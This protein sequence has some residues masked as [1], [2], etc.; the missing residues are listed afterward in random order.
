MIWFQVSQ[1]PNQLTPAAS[2]KHQPTN[3]LRAVNLPSFDCTLAYTCHLAFFLSGGPEHS[4]CK[5]DV[6]WTGKAPVCK[7][8]GMREACETVT[9]TPGLC[10]RTVTDLN[11]IRVPQG[12]YLFLRRHFSPFPLV[13]GLLGV[14]AVLGLGGC[15]G[16]SLVVVS[17]GCS[18]AEHGLQGAQASADAAQGL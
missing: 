5:A 10:T 3:T 4:T 8:K 16:L 18:A 9:K 17:R 14:L 6:K 1:F 11:Q 7:S 15:M 12:Y 13:T 2:L